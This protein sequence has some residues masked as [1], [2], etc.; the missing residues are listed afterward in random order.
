VA[1]VPPHRGEKG[2]EREVE[3]KVRAGMGDEN[4]RMQK[5]RQREKFHFGFNQAGMPNYMSQCFFL[6]FFFAQIG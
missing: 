2:Q 6:V 1:K 3:L 4:E 5:S